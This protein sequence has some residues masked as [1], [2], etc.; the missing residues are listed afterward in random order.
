[1]NGATAPTASQMTELLRKHYL[2]EY[3]QPEGIFA[4]EIGAPS[5]DRRADLIWQQISGRRRELIG[6]EIKVTRADLRHELNQPEKCTAWKQYCNRWWLVVPD[7]SIVDGFDIP[8]D[9]GIMLPPSGR[10]TRSMTVLREATK[11]TPATQDPALRTLAIWLFWRNQDLKTS[12]QQA[13]R[14]ADLQRTQ[15]ERLRTEN[16]ALE[17]F[18][19]QNTVLRLGHQ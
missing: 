6:H 14:E 15:I 12:E 2:P 7:K 18:R 19:R 8:D 17:K 5:G 4:P 13:H 11:L 10:R 3:R 9:W 16:E 1:M